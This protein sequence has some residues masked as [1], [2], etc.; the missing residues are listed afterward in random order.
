VASRKKE[1]LILENSQKGQ[2][3]PACLQASWPDELLPNSS[4]QRWAC[5]HLDHCFGLNAALLTPKKEMLENDDI[6]RRG[7]LSGI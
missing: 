6:P 4:M 7:L 5:A 1:I 3:P 2:D